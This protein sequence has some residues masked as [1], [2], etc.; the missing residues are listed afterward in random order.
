MAEVGIGSGCISVSLSNQIIDLRIYATD[1]S[2]SALNVAKQNFI[3]YSLKNF[4]LIQSD[5]LN[6]ISNKFDL[7][8][9]NLPYVPSSSLKLLP[10]S[11]YEPLQALDG[12]IDGLFYIRTFL[13]VAQNYLSRESMLLMEIESTQKNA[14]LEIAN[15]YFRNSSIQ[16]IDDLAHFPRLL[17]IQND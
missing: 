4:L 12:G 15:Q 14:V 16:V 6:C 10:V 9:A 2:L 11:K 5:L 3:Q 13:E 7:V 1:I 8:C 17:I